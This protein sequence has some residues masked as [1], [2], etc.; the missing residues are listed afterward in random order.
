MNFEDD[1]EDRS[2]GK[3]VEDDDAMNLSK[4]VP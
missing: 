1:E 2:L 3:D 4:R